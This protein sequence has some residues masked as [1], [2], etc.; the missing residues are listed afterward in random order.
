MG[1]TLDGRLLAPTHDGLLAWTLDKL[2]GGA[3]DGPLGR[4]L[5]GLLGLG[6]SAGYDRLLARRT[7][8]RR[9]PRGDDPQSP[10]TNPRQ[11]NSL[12]ERSKTA[13]HELSVGK[14]QELTEQLM[15]HTRWNSFIL[16]HGLSST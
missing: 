5:G 6:R 8:T 15:D 11:T 2:P 9:V 13:S 16:N 7:D 1:R 10:R 4:T 12:L 3:F 14:S